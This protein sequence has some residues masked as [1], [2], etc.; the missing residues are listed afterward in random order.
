MDSK[1]KPAKAKAANVRLKG[2]DD[3]TR[4]KKLTHVVSQ[5]MTEET[6]DLWYSKVVASGLTRSEFFRLCVL[7]NKT[8]VIAKKAASTDKLRVIYQV[9]KAGNN[10]NQLAWLAHQARKRGLLD[11]RAFEQ[12]L[13]HLSLISDTLQEKVESV[14]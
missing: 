2:D 13:R 8:E 6:Y 14:D 5:R 4:D 1:K 7:G 10:L 3:G 9:S 11:G 12:I